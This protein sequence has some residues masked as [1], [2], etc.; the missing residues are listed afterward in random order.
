MT[1]V[2]GDTNTDKYRLTWCDRVPRS[3]RNKPAKI[4]GI[5]HSEISDDVVAHIHTTS[6][7]TNCTLPLDFYRNLCYGATMMIKEQ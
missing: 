3:K 7:S 2:L 1:W 6:Q 5:Q 4:M